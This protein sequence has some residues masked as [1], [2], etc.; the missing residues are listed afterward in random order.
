V[1]SLGLSGFVTRVHYEVTVNCV[2]LLKAKFLT[3]RQKS[4]KGPWAAHTKYC[5]VIIRATLKRQFRVEHRGRYIIHDI[6][7][8]Y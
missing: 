4:A 2:R 7:D 1:G 8:K 3:W 6:V 5:L